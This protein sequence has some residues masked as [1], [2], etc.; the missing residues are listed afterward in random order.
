MDSTFS[1]SL[2]ALRMCTSLITSLM[3][4]IREDP[5]KLTSEK[6]H[7]TLGELHLSL[8]G[9]TWSLVVGCGKSHFTDVETE[10]QTSPIPPESGREILMLGPVQWLQDKCF[11][12]S[13]K[14]RY[15][16]GGLS[17]VCGGV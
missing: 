4:L 9:D 1:Y 7:R 16:P 15:F 2:S 14:K 17:Q 3:R 12:L 6:G 10:G 5:K 13:E 11:P 8:G